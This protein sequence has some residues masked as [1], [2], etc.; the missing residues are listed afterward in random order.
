MAREVNEAGIELIKTYEGCRLR[1]Y[2]DPGTGGDPWTI[3]YGHTGPEVVPGLIWTQE[4]ADARL[5]EDV[6][7][8]CEAVD[9]ALTVDVSD[10]EFAAMVCLTYN[11]GVGR[12]DDPDTAENE[13]RGFLGSTL[14]RLVNEGRMDE[15]ADQ[16]LRWNKSGGR[17]MAGLTRRR[18]AERALFLTPG[19][20]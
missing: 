20:G 15:A 1:A 17:V 4:E 19:N 3:G 5:V 18:E 9:D 16:F 13:G 11:I 2:P 12:V 6:E 7:R 10:N 8:F 14:L